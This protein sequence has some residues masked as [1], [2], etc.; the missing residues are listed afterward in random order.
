LNTFKDELLND[1]YLN[2]NIKKELLKKRWLL[3][4]L[5]FFIFNVE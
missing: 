5:S 4:K 2:E 1:K 3:Q